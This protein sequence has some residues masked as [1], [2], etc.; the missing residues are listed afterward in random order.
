MLAGLPMVAT[1]GVLIWVFSVIDGFLAVPEKFLF[2]FLF[3]SEVTIPGLGLVVMIL[4][5]FVVGFLILNYFTKWT[6]LVAGHFFERVPLIKMLY[7]SIKDL[8]DAF[9]GDN[10]HF[11]KPVLAQ[12]I[13]DSPLRMLGFITN[14]DLSAFSL[15]DRVAVFFPMAYNLGG[16]LCLLPRSA[17]TILDVKSGEVMK[18]IVSGGLSPI[19]LDP[20]K[21]Q[22]DPATNPPAKMDAPPVAVNA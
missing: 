1:I 5:T 14:E 22:T 8:F 6:M 10:K 2:K 12:V 13:P 18:F 20:P 15:T 11:D 9:V 21:S 7:S 3:N 17:I 16:G 4:I 19:Q